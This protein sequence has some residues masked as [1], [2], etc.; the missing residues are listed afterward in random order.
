MDLQNLPFNQKYNHNLMDLQ[1][2]MARQLA[3]LATVRI[4]PHIE[5]IK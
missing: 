4:M 1:A 3:E 5:Y 2:P